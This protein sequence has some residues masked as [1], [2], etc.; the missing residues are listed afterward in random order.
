MPGEGSGPGWVG[1]GGRGQ[2]AQGPQPPE[3]FDFVMSAERGQGR[4]QRRG[5]T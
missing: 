1:D 2:T 4:V 5:M 3:A